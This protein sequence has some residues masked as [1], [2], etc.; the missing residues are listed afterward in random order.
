MLRFYLYG[1]K[2]GLK[3]L[4]VA[5]GLVMERAKT[6]NTGSRMADQ[7]S[8]NEAGQVDFQHHARDYSRMIKMLKYGAIASLLIAFLV[9]II[10]SS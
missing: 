10:I 9:I 7:V 2:E 8:N 6:I 5:A 1:G 4:G 3:G